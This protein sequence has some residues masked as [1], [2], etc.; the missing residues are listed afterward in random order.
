MTQVYA[1][2][3]RAIAYGTALA[4]CGVGVGVACALHLLKSRTPSA[5]AESR[6]AHAQAG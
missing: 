6:R 3:V 4:L 2:G 5:L 1:T